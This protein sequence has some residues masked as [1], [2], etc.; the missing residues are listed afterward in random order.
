MRLGILTCPPSCSQVLQRG[1]DRLRRDPA[2]AT[3]PVERGE[4]GLVLVA[5]ADLDL[6][7]IGFVVTVVKA[8]ASVHG[9]EHGDDALTGVLSLH[10]GGD[11]VEHPLFVTADEAR[12]V[13]LEA[14][15]A[16][17]EELTT[18]HGLSVRGAVAWGATTWVIL[19]GGVVI[20]H[21]NRRH[22]DAVGQD[23]AGTVTRPTRPDG[24]AAS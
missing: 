5:C 21:P 10:E 13:A 18:F 24:S 19:Q 4:V 16:T 2:V 22:G 23:D 1:R 8:S 9:G 14:D 12:Q 15:A 6:N 11:V 7:P 17:P 20:P 3:H